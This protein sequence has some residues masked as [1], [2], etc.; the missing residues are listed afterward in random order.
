MTK[1]MPLHS[2]FNKKYF[3]EKKMLKEITNLCDEKQYKRFITLAV[4]HRC[5][6]KPSIYDPFELGRCVLYSCKFFHVSNHL[7]ALTP[8]NEKLS[9]I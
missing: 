3:D 6:V 2:C 5:V 7:L 1:A 8:L 9:S 4:C